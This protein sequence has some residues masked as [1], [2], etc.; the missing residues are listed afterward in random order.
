MQSLYSW[1]QDS[2]GAASRALEYAELAML[3]L[4]QS[5][6]A[7]SCLGVA[8]FRTGKY[9]QAVR[10]FRA[11]LEANPNDVR[12][13]FALAWGEATLGDSGAA[14]RHATEALRLSPKDLW[15]QLGYLCLAM[16]AFVERDHA[17]FVRWG[18]Q[19]VQVLPNAP[20]RRAMMVA[21]AGE[22]SDLDMQREHLAVLQQSTP[23]FIASLFRGENRLFA[24]D[25]HMEILL[26]GLR[27]AGLPE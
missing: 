17:A 1:G 24:K 16:A 14:R 26:S 13:M 11:A 21:Y 23:D 25:E 22:I 5:Q 19:A 7:Y 27:K 10:D 4:P 9:E 3:N 20:I 6:T 12:T 18:D 8:R 2:K 15:G